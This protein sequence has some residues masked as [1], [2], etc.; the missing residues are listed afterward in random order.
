[1]IQALKFSAVL[2]AALAMWAPAF[3]QDAPV[4]VEDETATV[5]DEAKP[6]VEDALEKLDDVAKQVDQ[7]SQ[8]QEVKSNILA[9]IYALAER[10][11]F[12]AFHWLAF[13]VMVTGVVSFALQLVLGKLVVL[14]RFGFSLTEVL[15]DALGLVVSL[16][17]LV[18]TTQAAT[19]NSSFTSSASAVISACAVGGLLGLIFYVWGQRQELQ[20]VEGRRKSAVAKP[21]ATEQRART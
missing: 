19:E 5:I 15:S 21:A 7:S 6:A 10:F 16:I 18:L 3:A 9:P 4:G 8:A 17:G 13:A 1:M 12:P 2:V 14:S 11:S 20:A